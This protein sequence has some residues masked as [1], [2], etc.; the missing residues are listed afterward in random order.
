MGHGLPRDHFEW[1]SLLMLGR[2]L[3]LVGAALCTVTCTDIAGLAHLLWYLCV[4]LKGV[5]D[6]MD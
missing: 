5:F 4:S 2:I 6:W 3:P 1:A